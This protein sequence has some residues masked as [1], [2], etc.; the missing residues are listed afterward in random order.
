MKRRTDIYAKKELILE[1]ISEGW[2]KADIC[3]EL[4]CKPLTLDGFLKEW[5]I[6]Y[7]GNQNHKGIKDIGYIP[8]ENYLND[9]K[10]I[11]SYKLVRKL[12][13]EGIKEKKCERCGLTEWLGEEIPLELHHKNGKHYD[14]H[15]ENI[16]I[17]CPN[18]HAFTENYRGKAKKKIDNA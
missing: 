13:K 15:L 1:W 3:K 5:G 11:T 7:K 17:L 4:V 8:V 16:L 6:D 2:S 9:T 14:N 12:F 10:R 18:C